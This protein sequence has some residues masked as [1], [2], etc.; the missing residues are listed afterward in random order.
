MDLA[1][2]LPPDRRHPRQA[3]LQEPPH[4]PHHG[5]ADVVPHPLVLGHLGLHPDVLAVLVRLPPEGH[6][7]DEV[8]GPVAK[9]GREPL[10]RLDLLLGWLQ[11]RWKPRAQPH[12]GPHPDP[13]VEEDRH[14]NA[15][16]L[17]VPDDGDP[18]PRD[19]SPHLGLDQVPHVPCVGQPVLPRALKPFERA[20]HS[21]ARDQLLHA[22]PDP[23]LAA[24]DPVGHAPH[25]RSLVGQHRHGMPS[26]REG[27][28]SSPALEILPRK[29]V[30]RSLGK[31]DL[32]PGQVQFLRHLQPPPAP[33]RVEA[34]QEDDRGGVLRLGR[35]HD[36]LQ[37]VFAIIF[38]AFCE[39]GALSGAAACQCASAPA[40]TPSSSPVAAIQ[41]PCTALR[42]AGWRGDAAEPFLIRPRQPWARNAVQR[43]HDG[44]G[45]GHWKEGHEDHRGPYRPRPH[46]HPQPTDRKS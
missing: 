24:E 11:R 26:E 29:R 34:M 23:N 25:E 28:Q 37:Q 38:G 20:H 21:D 7:H 10:E 13:Q 33:P 3:L 39:R 36:R 4:V 35:L 9:E 45:R 15:P 1:D 6:G 41:G 27:V 12:K 32:A 46:G 8:R 30:D 2:L 19:P 5:V 14:G 18:L 40:L 16:P 31:D 42:A 22:L 43:R 44:E 17:A